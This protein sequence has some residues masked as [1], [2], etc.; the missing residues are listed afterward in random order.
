[1]I[2]SLP[3]V[4]RIGRRGYGA[5]TMDFATAGGRFKYTIMF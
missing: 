5:M 3:D 1:M 2:G 4:R